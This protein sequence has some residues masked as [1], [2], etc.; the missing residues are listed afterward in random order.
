MDDAAVEITS[1]VASNLTPVH[2]AVAFVAGAA[3]AAGGNY[4]YRKV[5]VK[6]AAKNVETVIV[7][8]DD[9]VPA[10]K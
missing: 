10:G 6:M 2:L 8:P 7:T 4:V 1:D 9:F 3:I 5:R